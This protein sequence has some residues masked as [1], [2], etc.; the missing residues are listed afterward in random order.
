MEPLKNS[1]NEPNEFPGNSN[2]ER[3]AREKKDPP[4]K[5]QLSGAT[6]IKHESPFVS[7]YKAVFPGTMA[8]VKQS[9][10]DRAV[11][12]VQD[13]LY[14]TIVGFL[15]D[16]IYDGRGRGGGSAS[17][18]QRSS[19]TNPYWQG[20]KNAPALAPGYP[21]KTVVF[22]TRA[23]AESVLTAMIGYLTDYPSV[24]VAFYLDYSQQST[25]STDND[26]G[27]RSLDGVVAK[28]EGNGYILTLPPP[29][30]L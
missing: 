14:N 11:K 27:W 3:A 25:E 13:T 17:G 29:Q 4:P 28:P 23:D 7:F 9:L 6:E 8:R 21:F 1:L 26:W 16:Y 18:P 12:A 5:P 22:R 24:P 19:L 20:N 30:P 15:D 10:W 2:K